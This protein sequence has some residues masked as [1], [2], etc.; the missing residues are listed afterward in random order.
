MT[1]YVIPN[2][3]ELAESPRPMSDTKKLASPFLLIA[4]W[5]TRPFSGSEISGCDA[6]SA[7][8]CTHYYYLKV[9]F[10]QTSHAPDIGLVLKEFVIFIG[11]EPSGIATKEIS[12]KFAK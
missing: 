7:Q 6:S 11:F 1:Q 9:A 8:Y 5:K 2:Q 3:S 12:G 10:Q 4:A